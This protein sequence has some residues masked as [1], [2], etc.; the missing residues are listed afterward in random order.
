[1]YVGGNIVVGSG[2]AVACN[3]CTFSTIAQNQYN[4]G[5]TSPISGQVNSDIVDYTSFS[6]LVT[7]LPAANSLKVGTRIFVTDANATTFNSVAAGSGT[8][9]RIGG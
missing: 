9:W 1:M 6:F 7:N 2:A 8:N 5:F 3:N 4:S